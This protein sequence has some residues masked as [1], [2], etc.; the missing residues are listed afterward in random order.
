M[1]ELESLRE[2]ENLRFRFQMNN[3]LRLESLAAVSK[4]FREFGEPISD[5]LLSSL[6]FAVPNELIVSNGVGYVMGATTS[7]PEQHAVPGSG[8]Y[9]PP[10][11]PKPGPGPR[12][13]EPPAPPPGEPPAPPPGEPPAPPPPPG[14]PPV[15]PPRPGEPPVP[16]PRPGEPPVPPPTGRPPGR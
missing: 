12:P 3:R 10:P 14:E 16:P 2:A 4:V 9:P 7:P 1:E 5:D 11:G 13:G 6:V 15:P 8:S